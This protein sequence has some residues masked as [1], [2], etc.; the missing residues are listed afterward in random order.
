MQV[1]FPVL[2]GSVRKS[3]TLSHPCLNFPFNFML[4]VVKMAFRYQRESASHH[5]SLTRPAPH[6]LHTQIQPVASFKNKLAIGK[7]VWH[8]KGVGNS[9]DWFRSWYFQIHKKHLILCLSKYHVITPSQKLVAR[10]LGMMS[11]N[12]RSGFP[13]PRLFQGEDLAS[14]QWLGS[15]CITPCAIVMP[16]HKQ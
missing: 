16:V 10:Q 11:L 1:K 12:P 2:L 13:L 7:S 3:Q 5:Q 14:L 15:Q 4:Y 8:T 6:G 9:S